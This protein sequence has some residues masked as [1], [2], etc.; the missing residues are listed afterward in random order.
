MAEDTQFMLGT[1]NAKL[2]AV[3][4]SLEDHKTEITKRYDDH[5]RRLRALEQWRWMVVGAGA[6]GGSAMSFLLNRFT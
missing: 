6:A 4:R 1:L 3:L 5:D 2:D